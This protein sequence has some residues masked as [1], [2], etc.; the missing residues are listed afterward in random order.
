MS[1]MYLHLGKKTEVKISDII[2]IFDLDRTSMQ[3]ETREFL[4]EKEKEGKVVNVSDELPKSFTLAQNEEGE[5][6]YIGP[7]MASTLVSRLNLPNQIT[8]GEMEQ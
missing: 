1:K 8:L 2:G 7:L 4:Y 6:V 3:K 5:Q